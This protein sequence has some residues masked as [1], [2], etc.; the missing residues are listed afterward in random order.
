[1]VTPGNIACSFSATTGILTVTG[2]PSFDPP[3]PRSAEAT[4]EVQEED[5]DQAE[6]QTAQL[7]LY[8]NPATELVYFRIDGLDQQTAQLLL[9]DQS[10][11]LV[12]HRE[13]D[14]VPDGNLAFDLRDGNLKYGLYTAVLRTGKSV[15]TKRFVFAPIR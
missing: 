1:M 9:Y 2:V 4:Q 15:V 7:D 14:G 8:P 3:S 11:R 6:T 12:W 10:G 13:L 5:T